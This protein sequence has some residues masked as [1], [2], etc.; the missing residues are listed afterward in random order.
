MWEAVEF[1][2]MKNIIKSVFLLL[3]PLIVYNQKANAITSLALKPDCN[4]SIQM[5]KTFSAS[6]GDKFD[7]SAGFT[8]VINIM[9]SA[10][11]YHTLLVKAN[12]TP[13]FK[14]STYPDKAGPLSLG[15]A[16]IRSGV[17]IFISGTLVLLL[18]TLG[19]HYLNERSRAQKKLV[20]LEKELESKTLSFESVSDERDW[21]I[22][23]IHHRV[24]NN[25]QIV[26]SLLSSQ[27][28]YLKND[29]AIEAIRN[30]QHRMYAISL[31]HQKLYQT[32]SVSNVD[33]LIYMHELVTY[34]RDAYN[35]EDKINLVFD[36]VPLTLDI[37]QAL[38]LGLIINEAINNSLKYA[39]PVQ[40]KGD[41]KVSLSAAANGNYVFSIADNGIGL[42]HDHD[43][44]SPQSF[45]RSLMAGL[46]NQIG[47]TYEIRNNNGV[48]IIIRFNAGGKIS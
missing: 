1:Y 11:N 27:L 34:L 30:S 38:P 4:R 20:F 45:G 21:L 18:V 8:C 28:S 16:K 19:I 29:E 24:K 39:F 17:S 48:E 5:S 10:I 2:K 15:A 41:L 9:N 40:F 26:L 14:K 23:E 32:G 12:Y 36:L 22:K 44:Y 33:M 25:L 6:P 35:A 42:K 47:G 3:L 7:N 31:V 37:N 43:L 46:A 13:A